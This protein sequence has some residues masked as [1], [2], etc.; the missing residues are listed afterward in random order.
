MKHL[1]TTIVLV[2]L[3]YTGFSQKIYFSDTSNRW[4]VFVSTCGLVPYSEAFVNYRYEGDTVLAGVTYRKLFPG[5]PKYFIR[6]DTV[7]KK[8]FIKAYGLQYVDTN[9]MVLYDYN[10][11]LGDTMRVNWY[12]LH[13][14]YRVQSLD[15]TLIGNHYY[16]VWTMK[17]DS[18][19]PVSNP[20]NYATYE[21]KV[22]EGI[23]C[24]ADPR[25]PIYPYFFEGCEWLTC[26]HMFDNTT[27]CAFTKVE[28]TALHN[29]ATIYP[30]P[31][32]STSVVQLKQPLASGQLSIY[33]ILGRLVHH[34]SVNNETK[35]PVGKYLPVPGQYF[36][37]II[38]Y[39]Q[40]Q[41]YTGKFIFE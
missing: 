38:D 19:G 39:D 9:E 25:Y 23:G 41:T 7:Q 15:S 35:I 18:F 8:V 28:E 5:G 14:T 26:F 16:K 29:T 34:A 11:N 30:N 1:F 12:N 4:R 21:Y 20:Y 10:L 6:E 31:A 24:L 2:L 40:R 3:A 37:K 17:N 33:N 13:A 27:S 36:F 32:N 22:I